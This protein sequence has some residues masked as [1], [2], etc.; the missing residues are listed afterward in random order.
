MRKNVAIRQRDI[1]KLMKN[2]GEALEYHPKY[3][4]TLVGRGCANFMGTVHIEDVTEEQEKKPG[5]PAGIRGMK[6]GTGRRSTQDYTQV[7]LGDMTRYIELCSDLIQTRSKKGVRPS[8]AVT[9]AIVASK[10]VRS[11]SEWTG[12]SPRWA[13]K[14]WLA[15]NI[16]SEEEASNG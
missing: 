6:K 5:R 7:E 10:P 1:K 12:P 11:L 8:L 15:Q 2:F 9:V 13:A 14:A 4:K 3:L 16:F